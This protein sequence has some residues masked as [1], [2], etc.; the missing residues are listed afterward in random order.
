[1][2]GLSPQD[3]GKTVSATPPERKSNVWSQ[4][5]ITQSEITMYRG[6]LSVIKKLAS[7]DI[8]ISMSFITTAT[9]IIINILNLKR[10]LKTSCSLN[11]QIIY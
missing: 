3:R 1:M 10:R 8:K 6:S 2:N 9:I 5:Q 11:S 7:F 4:R